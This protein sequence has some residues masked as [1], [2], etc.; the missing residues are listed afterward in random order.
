MEHPQSF[1][2]YPLPEVLP[3]DCELV[4][5][6]EDHILTLVVAGEIAVQQLLT[7]QEMRAIIALVEALPGGCTHAALYVAVNNVYLESAE[8]LM[9]KA[10]EEAMLSLVMASVR[11]VLRS[12]AAKLAPCDLGIQPVDET[13]YRLFGCKFSKWGW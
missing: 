9:R 11:N 5:N 4:M 1:K 10:N 6:L 12:C 7:P 3:N 8:D 13:G 2:T